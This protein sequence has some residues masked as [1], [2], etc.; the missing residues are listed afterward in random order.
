VQEGTPVVKQA[1]AETKVVVRDA[2]TVIIGGLIQNRKDNTTKSVPLL[3]QIPLLGRLFRQ[4]TISESDSE[5]IV[6]LTPRIV[7]GEESS[8]RDGQKKAPKLL[9]TGG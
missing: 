2:V 3:G 1:V 5:I 4:D 6:F 8:Q 9:K 7:S